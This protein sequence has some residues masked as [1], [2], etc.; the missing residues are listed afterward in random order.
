M[1]SAVAGG[2][3]TVA[4]TSDRLFAAP[5]SFAANFEISLGLFGY[6]AESLPEL[7]AFLQ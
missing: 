5:Y 7:L 4:P 3:A 1:R 6:I 2:L